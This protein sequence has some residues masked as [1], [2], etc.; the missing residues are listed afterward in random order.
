MCD[1]LA[2]LT[3]ILAALRDQL[4]HRAGR[5]RDGAAVADLLPNP[6]PRLYSC[7]LA[8]HLLTDHAGDLMPRAVA[9]SVAAAQALVG[10]M[11]LAPKAV[12]DARAPLLVGLKGY[13]E[14]LL[15]RCDDAAEGVA[16]GDFSGLADEPL[17]G[18]LI[19]TCRSLTVIRGAGL[20]TAAQQQAAGQL[21]LLLLSSRSRRS[22]LRGRLAAIGFRIE[23]LGSASEAWRRCQRRPW[24]A[25]ILCDNLAPTRHL[26]SLGQLQTRHARR[27]LPALV[28]VASGRRVAV[29]RQAR[30]LRATGAW[31]FPYALV[32]L[33]EILALD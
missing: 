26:Q 9:N 15:A 23:L 1:R 24:P 2:Q 3:S 18:R 29:Q 7:L 27:A 6:D 5:S 31:T 10:E 11:Q 21:V 8:T 20:Q 33:I 30:I 19:E 4:R 14:T 13:L 32:D 16:R 12:V 25:A 17:V 22:T 28:L